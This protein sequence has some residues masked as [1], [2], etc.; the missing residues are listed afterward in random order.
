MQSCAHSVQWLG[1]FGWKIV[2]HGVNC[3]S[4]S[5]GADTAEHGRATKC[6]LHVTATHGCRHVMSG[7]K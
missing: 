1:L 2:Q 4:G 5:W 6:T 3:Q 7:G